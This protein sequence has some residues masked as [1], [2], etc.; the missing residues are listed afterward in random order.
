MNIE[1]LKQEFEEFDKNKFDKYK[2]LISSK[3]K[4]E[5]FPPYI[6]HIGLKY[7]KY[8]LMMYGMA[9]SIDKPWPDLIN[10]TNAEKV[11]QLYDATDYNNTW[12]A[13][14]KVMLAIAG[15]YIYANYQDMV[16]SFDELHNLITATN[17]YK[18]SFRYNGNDVNPNTDLS[19]H[20][21]PDLYWQEN[22]ELSVS[23]LE[24]LQPSMILSFKGRHNDIIKK[25]GYNYIEINDP[26]WILQGGGGVLKKGGSWDLETHD[27]SVHQLV[28]SYLNQINDKYSA[29]K[30][31]IRIYLLKYFNDWK[32]A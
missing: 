6:P 20:E 17:Y 15:T 32:N 31:A 21:S 23:E 28:D 7:D 22:D 8:K 29:K 1:K 4:E 14:Y 16:D 12:I 9:Q 19:N 30:E 26:S 5:I 18:F 13:P 24:L 25:Q 27:N 3:D 2:H 11:T 10:K